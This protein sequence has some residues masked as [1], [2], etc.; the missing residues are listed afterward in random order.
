MYQHIFTTISNEPADCRRVIERGAFA[1]A[2]INARTQLR[3]TLT[4]FI[5]LIEP[6]GEMIGIYFSDAA[7][8]LNKRPEKLS[9]D[10]LWLSVDVNINVNVNYCHL[11]WLRF[12]FGRSM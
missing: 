11:N 2:F 6:N 9:I 10:F 1:F 3:P 5:D 4:E 7:E 12:E 8:T